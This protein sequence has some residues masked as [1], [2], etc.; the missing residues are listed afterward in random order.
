M[1][2]P[3]A[4]IE[5]QAIQTVADAISE[6][7]L[8]VAG[9]PD[10][11]ST[12]GTGNQSLAI[13]GVGDS[14]ELSLQIHGI[15]V[16]TPERV[17][18]LLRHRQQPHRKGR[19][20][21]LVADALPETSRKLL[22]ARG[23]AWIDRRGE[24]DLRAPGVFIRTTIRPQPRDT[25]PRPTQPIRGVAGISWALALLLNPQNPPGVRATARDANLSP[26]TISTAKQQLQ[27][28]ALARD[29]NTPVIPDLF[30]ALADVWNPR[31]VALASVPDPKMFAP[32]DLAVTGDVAASLHGAPVPILADQPPDLYVSSQADLRRLQARFGNEPNWP[33]RAC[34]AAVAPTPLALHTASA[35]Q[36]SFGV[37]HAVVAALDLAKDRVRGAE[38]LQNWRPDD[39]D[40]VW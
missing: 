3:R 31:R 2:T 21:L 27:D 18:A 1:R 4:D 20:D 35:H 24:M 37:V 14:G 13:R 32:Q 26:S 16:A 29:E 38:I 30:W 34:S 19:L 15:T 11:L 10:V 8:E 33:D 9:S 39:F 23:W 5:D 36:G 17:A 6:L 40:R 28:A 25:A 22:E 12:D 7:G